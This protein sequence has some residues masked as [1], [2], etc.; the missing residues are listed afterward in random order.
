MAEHVR[1]TWEVMGF[2][3]HADTLVATWVVM[4]ILLIIGWRAGRAVSNRV[5]QGAQNVF[6]LVL[7]FL[8]GL[9]QENM[10]HK[11]G[12]SL[13]PYFATLIMF[14]LFSNMLG[15]FP[16]LT[17][18]AGHIFGAPNLMSPTADLSTTFALATLTFFLFNIWGFRFM[19]AKYIPHSFAHPNIAFFLINI[20]EMVAKPVTLAFRLYGNIFAGEVLIAVLLGFF[21]IS[22]GYLLGGWMCQVVWLGFSVF[23]GCIQAF[24]FTILTIVYTSQAIAGEE[25]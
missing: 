4:G 24:V 5:P 8:G 22:L 10:G 9:V 17:F 23:I 2:N 6:E 7:E 14:I 3:L 12:G 1:L 19:G 11:K 16:N 15:L 18:G 21:P 20:V 25:H 13:L